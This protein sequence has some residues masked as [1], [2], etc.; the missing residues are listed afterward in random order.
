MAK[1][2]R[3]ARSLWERCHAPMPAQAAAA[4]Q[5]PAKRAEHR[6]QQRAHL[7]DSDA[8]LRHQLSEGSDRKDYGID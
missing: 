1:K 5:H 4:E 3:E 7:T 8:Y 6:R 2:K